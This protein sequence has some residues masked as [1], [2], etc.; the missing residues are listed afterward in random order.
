MTVYKIDTIDVDGKPEMQFKCLS[1]P[2][3]IFL[4]L[5]R[6]VDVIRGRKAREIEGCRLV[7]RASR[8]V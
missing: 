1:L 3:H 6:W 7:K 5:F 2:D 4:F 8:K